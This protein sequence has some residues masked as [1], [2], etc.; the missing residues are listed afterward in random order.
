[1]LTRQTIKRARRIERRYRELESDE[2]YCDFASRR[3]FGCDS[4]EHAPP[5]PQAAQTAGPHV[6]KRD[7]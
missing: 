5:C 2:C 1:M 6:S 3:F 4:V 7:A